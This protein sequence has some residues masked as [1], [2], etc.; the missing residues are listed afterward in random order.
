M[1]LVLGLP[2]SLGQ[3]MSAE[4]ESG[5]VDPLT[6]QKNSTEARISAIQAMLNGLDNNLLDANTAKERITLLKSELDIILAHIE[7]LSDPVITPEFVN[8]LGLMDIGFNN[9]NPTWT[10][11]GQNLG[12][13]R[14]NAQSK[15]IIIADK[16][17]NIL[18]TVKYKSKEPDDLGL[19]L[20]LPEFSNNSSYNAGLSWSP[21]NSQFIFMSNG[22]DSNYDLYLGSVGN[23]ISTRLTTHDEKDGHADWSPT[24]NSIAFISGRSGNANVYLYDTASKIISQISDDPLAFLYPQW[25]PHGDRLAVTLGSN[26][27]HNVIIYENLEGETKNITHRSLISW[28]YDDLRPIWS[29]DGSKIAFYTNYNEQNDSKVWAIAIVDADSHE[30]KTAEDI[31]PLIVATDVIPDVDKGPAWMPDSENIVYV[32]KNRKR[33]N[34]IHLVNINDK[35]SKRIVTD[36]KINHDVSCSAEGIIAFRSQVNQWDQMF[37]TKLP[38]T[39]RKVIS[40][41]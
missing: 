13:E 16:I 30:L 39:N 36:T 29:P 32:Q 10:S 38:G 23:E 7:R 18:Q 31:I 14:H 8:P 33:Y 1:V 37:V 6:A 25:S 21:D 15:E 3:A 17:G 34:P 28:K 12:F 20:L 26:E 4:Q 19:D 27:N 35:V 22:D 24:G 2:F 41:K 5:E 9:S 40:N 11:D